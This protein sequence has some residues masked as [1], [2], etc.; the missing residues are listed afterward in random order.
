MNS[1]LTPASLNWLAIVGKTG[2]S[3]GGVLKSLRLRATCLRTSRSASSAPRFSNLLSTTKSAKSSM[4]IFSSWLARAIVGRHHVHRQVD[5]IHDFGVALPD[6]CSL[7]H[8]EVEARRFQELHRVR[9]H[10]GGRQVLA[11]RRERTHEEL[12]VR[13]RIHADAVAEQ[14]AARAAPGRVHRDDR[15]AAFREEPDHAVQEF[16]RQRGLAGTAGARDA[17]DGRP[18]QG[19][20]GVAAQARDRR[21]VALLE[22]GDRA[23]KIHRVVRGN[24]AALELAGAALH[25]RGGTRPRSSR[26]GR[27]SARRPACRSSRCRRPRAPRLRAGAIVP[28]PPTTTLMCAAPSDFS[29]ST[30]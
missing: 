2:S 7:D 29:M 23:G 13:Q 20:G 27:A 8:D 17:D 4:S 21:L 25:A 19:L 9:E 3:S 5:E 12:A 14:R 24:A 22:H 1:V 16:V 15:D 11:S 28:P 10:G 26:R 30:M 6:P 18:V